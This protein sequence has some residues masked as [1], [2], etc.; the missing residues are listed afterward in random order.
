MEVGDDPNDED[1]DKNWYASEEDSNVED[2]VDLDEDWY[3]SEEDSNG[4]DDVDLDE[5]WYGSEE[6]G[7]DDEDEDDSE[8][9]EQP[10]P[11]P[12]QIK[13]VVVKLRNVT[14]YNLELTHVLNFD[15]TLTPEL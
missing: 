15:E 2:D 3:G 7:K 4:K 8:D 14:S 1:W 9:D 11:P 12:P 6:D 10:P 13:P 5:D